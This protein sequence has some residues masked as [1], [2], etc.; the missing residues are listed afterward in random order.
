MPARFEVR[1]LHTTHAL[2][3]ARCADREQ[4]TLPFQTGFGSYA[5]ALVVRVGSEHAPVQS[6][7]DCPDPMNDEVRIYGYTL[8]LDAITGEGLDAIP[9]SGCI[10]C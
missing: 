7:L 9:G 5:A 2:R 3:F 8:T 6:D 1:T 10:V 4:R